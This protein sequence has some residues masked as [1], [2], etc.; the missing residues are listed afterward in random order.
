MIH[1]IVSTE[2]LKPTFG[3]PEDFVKKFLADEP[4]NPSTTSEQSSNAPQN[5]QNVVLENSV[6]E[7]EEAPTKT[8]PDT[9]NTPSIPSTS[10]PKNSKPRKKIRFH[11]ENTYFSLSDFVPQAPKRTRKKKN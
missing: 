7:V 1:K 9:Q 10:A 6:T 5:I 4:L 3:I 2:R 8:Q 11:D